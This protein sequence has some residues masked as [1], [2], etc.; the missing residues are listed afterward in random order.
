VARSLG[1]RV[2]SLSGAPHG[3]AVARNRGAAIAQ[4]DILLFFDAD[5]V[6]HP[7]TVAL[8]EHYLS[9]EPPIAALFGSYD[10]AP[11]G[12][13]LTARYKNLMHHY[14]HQHA[15]RE[16][17]P[18]WTGCGA[19][20]REAFVAIGGFDESYIRPSIED[21]ELG[22]RLRQAGYRIRLCPEV[23]ATHLKQWIFTGLLRA[24]IRDRAVPWTKLIVHSQNLPNDLNLDL[25]SRLSA[26]AAWTALA[27][28]VAAL[29]WPWAGVGALFALVLIAGLNAGLYRFFA[30]CGGS[31]FMFGAAGLHLLYL[32][33]SSAT[34]AVVAARA[35][36]DRRT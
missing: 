31:L 7:D 8:M 6:V 18:F 33:Y 19:I 30:R 29:F 13:S 36:P 16:A 27:G 4:G 25:N 17:G 11:P 1:A 9:V 3:P 22:L 5:V 28:T 21:I 24:D 14:V 32:L 10:A 2:I 35:W 34:F 23:Q 15:R 12:Q 20:R 26:L